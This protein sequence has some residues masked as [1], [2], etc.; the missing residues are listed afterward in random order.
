MDG[1]PRSPKTG[2]EQLNH[3]LVNLPRQPTDDYAI[4][5]YVLAA[6]FNA[7]MASEHPT[8]RK[9]MIQAEGYYRIACSDETEVGTGARLDD[10]F[11]KEAHSEHELT[12]RPLGI[13]NQPIGSDH[14]LTG[15]QA[16][17]A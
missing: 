11:V 10:I 2:D 12:L 3:I 15:C 4:D 13:H 16:D 1:N 14:H 8:Q 5:L 17:P 7:E 6:D 9:T